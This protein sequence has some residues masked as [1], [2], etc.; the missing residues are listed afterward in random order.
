MESFT[1]T[2]IGFVLS[3]LTWMVVS[4]AYG[5]PMSFSTNLQITGWFTIVSIVRQYVLRRLFDGRSPW[6]AFKEKFS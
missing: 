2:A 5:I 6:A 1:N 3:L 4:W